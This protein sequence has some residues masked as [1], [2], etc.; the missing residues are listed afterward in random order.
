MMRKPNDYQDLIT[1]LRRLATP[2]KQVND[3]MSYLLQHVEY[4]YEEFDKIKANSEIIAKFRNGPRDR[5]RG[6]A[7]MSFEEGVKFL[8]L[9]PMQ[10]GIYKDGLLTKGVCKEFVAFIMQ[11]CAELG[12]QNDHIRGAAAYKEGRLVHVWNKI[13]VHPKFQMLNYDITNAITLRD[14]LRNNTEWA[15]R[16]KTSP[17]DWLGATDTRLAKLAPDMKVISINDVLVK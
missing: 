11:V 5:I 2:K 17:H 13:K 1:K 7:Q 12:I 9:A 10:G 14:G 3:L 16:Q 15:L 8:G 4:D 6:L